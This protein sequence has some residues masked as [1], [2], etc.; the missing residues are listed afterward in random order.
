MNSSELLLSSVSVS[1]CTKENSSNNKLSVE[2]PKQSRIKEFKGRYKVYDF[3]PR[4]LSE[5]NCYTI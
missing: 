2:E 1:Q 3:I 4:F 5:T